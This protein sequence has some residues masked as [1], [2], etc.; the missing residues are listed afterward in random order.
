M[1]QYVLDP[2]QKGSL[3]LSLSSE[4]EKF[5]IKGILLVHTKVIYRNSI[6][7]RKRQLNCLRSAGCHVRKGVYA[8]GMDN[9][10]SL[11][12]CLN[13][14]EAALPDSC[15][16]AERPIK[17]GLLADQSIEKLRIAG[18]IPVDDLRIIGHLHPLSPVAEIGGNF[19]AHIGPGKIS[20]DVH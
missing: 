2:A 12:F 6:L 11:F 4:V 15:R 5:L 3:N 20:G 1:P 16:D 9:C 14:A 10:P 18:G 19:N 13:R 7:S 17:S 8:T